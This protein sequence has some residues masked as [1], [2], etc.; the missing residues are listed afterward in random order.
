MASRRNA[1]RSKRR[2]TFRIGRL[3]FWTVLIV[4]TLWLV[5]FVRATGSILPPTPK[6]VPAPTANAL[7]SALPTESPIESEQSDEI[8]IQEMLKQKGSKG[9]T[10]AGGTTDKE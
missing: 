1:S 10:P 8:R 5:A 4:E 6:N 2:S 3:L 7:I 9:N